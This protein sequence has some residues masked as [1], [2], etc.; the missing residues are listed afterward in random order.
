MSSKCVFLNIFRLFQN[1]FLDICNTFRYY[2][3]FDFCNIF[4]HFYVFRLSHRFFNIFQLFN[5]CS[6]YRFVQLFTFWKFFDFNVCSTV[7]TFLDL[8]F[9]KILQHQ[10]TLFDFWNIF[11]LFNLKKLETWKH[12]LLIRPH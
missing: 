8:N 6:N 5:I 4:L 3:R 11:R 10:S 2:Q 1:I 7:I 12:F 9:F